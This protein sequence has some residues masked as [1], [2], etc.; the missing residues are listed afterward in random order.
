MQQAIQ[1]SIQAPNLDDYM[2]QKK[3][4]LM[5]EINNKKISSELNNVNNIIAK[6]NEDIR[7]IR[8]QLSENRTNQIQKIESPKTE[9]ISENYEAAAQS[10]T[11]AKNNSNNEQLK[12]RYG[13]YQ[14]E[15]VSIG[16][17]FYF[18]SKR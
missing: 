11:S 3:F 6:L 15:D 18:G 7:Q 5:I 2:L 17:F 4:E 14:P 9:T 13:D 16:K 1:S 12:P 10:F 8:K